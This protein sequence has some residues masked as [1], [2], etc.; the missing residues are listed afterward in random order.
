[1]LNKG[2]ASLEVSRSHEQRLEPRV[3]EF[4]EFGTASLR[5]ITV[6]VVSK[7]LEFEGSLIEKLLLLMGSIN[8]VN[9]KKTKSRHSLKSNT[10]LT[11]CLLCY[12]VTPKNSMTTLYCCKV[13]EK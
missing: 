3:R 5:G 8:S 13:V 12:R 1:M 9:C 11:C 6:C 10:L 2:T 4:R 7:F